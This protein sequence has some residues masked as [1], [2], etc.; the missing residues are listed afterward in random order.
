MKQRLSYHKPGN[1]SIHNDALETQICND[2]TYSIAYY[3]IIGH[4]YRSVY[5]GIH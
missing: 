2:L 3:F 5:L 4:I 1:H